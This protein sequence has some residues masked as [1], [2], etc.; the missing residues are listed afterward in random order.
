LNL[1][2]SSGIKW[3]NAHRREPIETARDRSL[4]DRARNGELDA[5]DDG[6]STTTIIDC[7]IPPGPS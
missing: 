5:F 3:S 2:A 6:K 4:V 1:V 7:F